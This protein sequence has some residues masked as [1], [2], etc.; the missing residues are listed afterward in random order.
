MPRYPES[1]GC[2]KSEVVFICFCLGI[3][4]LQALVFGNISK[5]TF[6]NNYLTVKLKINT[7]QNKLTHTRTKH[8]IGDVIKLTHIRQ[9]IS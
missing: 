7:T 6:V 1:D 9:N 5:R 2:V 3:Y 8:H 4:K